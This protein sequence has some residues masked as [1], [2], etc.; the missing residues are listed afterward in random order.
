MFVVSDYPLAVVLC[1]VTMLCWGSW[2][3]TQKAA[4]KGWRFELFYWDYVF[5][6]V[7]LATISAF[8][9]GSH[10]STGR[11]FLADAKLAHF[12]MILSAL[13]GGVVFN[14][15][16]ILLVAAISIA[17]MSVAFPV[18]IGL[19]LIVGVGVNYDWQ[20]PD[21]A[22]NLAL[23]VT[24]VVLV[25]GAIVCN[26]V[27]YRRLP[28]QDRGLSTKG[29]VL[30]VCCGV[31]MGFFY[32]LV[33]RT[34]FNDPLRP[35]DGFLSPYTAVYFFALGILA[36]NLIF[37]RVIM[38][39]PFVGEPVTWNDYR[40]GTVWQHVL[41]VL[42]GVIW[43]VGMTLNIV[44]ST[45]ATP[46]ISYGLGQGATM[47]AAIWGVFVWREFRDA[48]RGTNRLLGLMFLLY[49]AG[50]GLIIAARIPEAKKPPQPAA[51]L[52]ATPPATP[53]YHG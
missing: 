36:S 11:S 42:G 8:T 23:L 15:A 39:K 31:L 48:P 30:S 43:C 19:A 50:L 7:I 41:G 5:G 17:G 46:A 26:A 40:K 29:L 49:L 47:V 18:G 52:T 10:G 21:P 35:Q 6:V 32:L 25:T 2:A 44:A 33:A 16:N 13:A 9:L 3:N 4:G 51:E 28:G 24:G 20:D 12:E 53:W 37:N 38:A 14:L 1:V 34:L 27:A 45:E 22:G